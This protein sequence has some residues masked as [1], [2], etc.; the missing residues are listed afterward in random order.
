[1]SSFTQAAYEILKVEGKPL[2]TKNILEKA[3]SKGII[4][5]N[6]KTPEQTLWSS[7][8]SENKRRLESHSKGKVPKPRFKR[9][10]NGV[11]SLTEWDEK[12]R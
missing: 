12:S 9:D 3:L 2:S 6:G 4:K 8:Y 7:L 1:M 11:W 10:K 5:T